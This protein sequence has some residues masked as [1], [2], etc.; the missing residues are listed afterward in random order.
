MISW[1]TALET[2][3]YDT[4]LCIHIIVWHTLL[5]FLVS[6]LLF[7]HIERFTVFL[8]PFCLGLM[9]Y[10]QKCFNA[11]GKQ[12]KIARLVMQ[13]VMA[14]VKEVHEVQSG[15]ALKIQFLT[16]REETRSGFEYR[17]STTPTTSTAS[18]P[19]GSRCS[20]TRIGLRHPGSGLPLLG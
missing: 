3:T 10:E 13:E 14:R 12:S 6:V 18:D 5:Y 8:V 7:E 20:H 17:Y 9:S 1:D 2:A 19:S 15:E 16:A 11:V 4:F